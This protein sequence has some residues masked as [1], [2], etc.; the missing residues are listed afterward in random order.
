ML[1]PV[2]ILIGWLYNRS[3][4]VQAN[5]EAPARSKSI[6]IPW[7]VFGFLGMVALNSVIQFPPIV[8]DGLKQIAQLSLT[9]AMAALGL[10]TRYQAVKA[11]GI[12]PILLSSLLFI[13]LLVGG[14]A[15]HQLLY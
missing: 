11:A 9:I 1:A 8:S 3:K 6:P 2:V 15:A 4:E 12:A 10:Q 7:F 14:F 5:C 13:L